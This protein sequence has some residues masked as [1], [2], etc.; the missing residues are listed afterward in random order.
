M[1]VCRWGAPGI[2][3]TS[4]LAHPRISRPLVLDCPR[5][6]EEFLSA[7]RPVLCDSLETS[8]Y[9]YR[10]RP[11]GLRLVHRTARNRHGYLSLSTTATGRLMESSFKVFKHPSPPS[12]TSCLPRY[13]ERVRITTQLTT[14]NA[15][16][17]NYVGPALSASLVSRL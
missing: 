7:R 11:D 3:R 12:V 10:F 2:R 16:Q 8:R 4:I 15:L 13:T 5:L 14:V 17:G 6:S 1:G 9:F